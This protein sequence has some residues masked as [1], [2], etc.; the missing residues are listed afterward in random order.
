[1]QIGSAQR[2]NSETFLVHIFGRGLDDELTITER[3]IA[4]S[5]GDGT[6]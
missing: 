5:I 4:I 1:M 2:G 3:R 6:V